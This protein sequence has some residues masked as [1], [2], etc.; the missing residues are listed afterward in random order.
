MCVVSDTLRPRDRSSEIPSRRRSVRVVRALKRT[1]RR[2][3]CA[4]CLNEFT[5]SLIRHAVYCSR[6]CYLGAKKA[7]SGLRR[8]EKAEARAIARRAECEMCGKVFLR[9]NCRRLYCSNDCSKSAAAEAAR[10]KYYG[11]VLPVC[12]EC[13]APRDT[14][15]R[16]NRYCG[17]ACRKKRHCDSKR[18]GKQRR[19]AAKRR[20]R[21]DA[22]NSIEVFAR[23]KWRCQRCGC[24][25]F[26]RYNPESLDRSPTLDHIIP[27]SKGGPHTMANCQ[28][29]CWACN[30]DKSDTIGGDQLR[31]DYA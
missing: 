26:R 24:K 7:R 30:T 9:Q 20:V 29:L 16:N 2:P 31:L 25:C 6:D 21:V 8:I 11:E 14:S 12:I 19:R 10:S 15:I 23:D 28:L 17:E 1:G 18:T 3:R 13:G 4:H 27:L 5:P 22:F